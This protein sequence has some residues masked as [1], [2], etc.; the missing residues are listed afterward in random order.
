MSDI[1]K[2]P[3]KIMSFGY[4]YG[5][6][7][8]VNFLQD[9]R[10]LPNPYYDAD[11]KEKTGLCPEVRAYVKNSEIT[12]EYFLK[13]NSLSEFYAKMFTECNRESLTVAIGCTGGRHRSVTIAIELG[14]YLSDKGYD[15]TVFHR[16]IH[17]DK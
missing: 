9:V 10:F 4:K 13:L 16:D 15:V 5:V 11:L 2:L 14:T 12:S 6:P 8:D 3:I 1:Q 17:K 7:C